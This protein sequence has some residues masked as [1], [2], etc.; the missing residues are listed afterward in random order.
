[1]DV[2]GALARVLDRR[3]AEIR[4]AAFDLVEHLV[5]RRHCQRMHGVAEVLEYGGLRER[6]LRPEV[7]DLQRLLLREAGGHQ[8]A[9]QPHHLLVAQRP[10]VALDDF[11]QHLR[12]A[13]RSVELGGAS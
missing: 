11:A 7:C 3:H 2:D 6:A 10:V 8:L 1:M 13:L 5:D 12:L 4:R 9:E